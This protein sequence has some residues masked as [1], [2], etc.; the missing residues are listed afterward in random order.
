MQFLPFKDREVADR[1]AEGLLKAGMEGTPSGYYKILEENRLTAE[2]IKELQIG[3][4]VTG[5]HIW[6]GGQWWLE[7]SEDG[8]KFKYWTKIKDKDFSGSGM[9]CVEGGLRCLQW[10]KHLSGL[11]YCYHIYR[12]P[13]GTHEEKNEYL[14]MTDLGIHSFSAVK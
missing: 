10:N 14:M 3:R 7:Y 6:T 9:S 8:K 2:E 1:Y 4:T 5:I 12:N 13:E 11:K